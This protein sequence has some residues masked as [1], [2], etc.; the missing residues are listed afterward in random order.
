LRADRNTKLAS[1]FAIIA[2][3]QLAARLR[4]RSGGYERGSQCCEAHDGALRHHG[5]P[6]LEGLHEI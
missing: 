5:P 3:F 6:P 4:G 2:I 1:L